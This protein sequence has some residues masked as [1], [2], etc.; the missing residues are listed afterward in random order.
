MDYQTKLN[1][2]NQLFVKI[3]KEKQINSVNFIILGNSFASGYTINS[4]IKLFFDR[5]Q[6]L[7]S[8][9]EK[10][11]IKF[12]TFHFAQPYKNSN[13]TIL[14]WIQ[15][16]QTQKEVLDQQIKHYF[17]GPRKEIDKY[18]I[19]LRTLK[20][21]FSKNI[22]DK[23]GLE[24]L[25]KTQ[26]KNHLNIIIFIANTGE[27]M[28]YVENKKFSNSCKAILRGAK[29]DLI[30][31]KKTINYIHKLNPQNLI[32]IMNIPFHEKFPFLFL[33]GIIFLFNWIIPIYIGKIP[34]LIFT[35]GG[36]IEAKYYRVGDQ[37]IFD[38]HPDKK[39]YTKMLY[40]YIYGINKNYSKITH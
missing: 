14:S 22:K 1:E 33:D 27:T 30:Y 28:E 25:I 15:N 17:S 4:K 26:P 29:K 9:L 35:Q 10:A 32:T 19:N 16:N 8:N 20:K 21:Y 13:Q 38:P 2:Q 36:T 39:H 5:N 31:C 11:K 3:L 37:K 23:R 24:D 12:D 6:N 40:C 34:N 7:F 18:N